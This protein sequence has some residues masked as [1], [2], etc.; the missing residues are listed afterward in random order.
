MPVSQPP[1][2][3]SRAFLHL[4]RGFRLLERSAKCCE[5]VTLAQCTLL[6]TLQE[7]GVLRLKALAERVGVQ[8]STA[9]RLVDAAERQGLVIRR[10]APGDA[11]GVR[12]ELTEEGERMAE[13][14]SA[15]GSGFCS[16]ILEALPQRERQKTIATIERVANIV[17][18]LPTRQCG[19]Q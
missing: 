5:G 14:I 15:A 4:V 17:D 1:E 16:L 6:E 2:A 10:P 8:I 19:G 18:S 12:V 11:R 9:T 3:L 7:E 13:K